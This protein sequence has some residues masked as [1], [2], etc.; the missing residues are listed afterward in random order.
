MLANNHPIIGQIEKMSDIEKLHLVD[1]ILARLD[2][3]D[4]EIDRFWSN[5]AAS[6]WKAYKAGKLKTVSYDEVM[7]KYQ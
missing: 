1:Y 5:E 4:P 2:R 6:R 3:P 7:S